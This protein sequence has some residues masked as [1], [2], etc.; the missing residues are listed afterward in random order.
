M[1]NIGIAKFE[2]DEPVSAAWRLVVTSADMSTEMTTVE[3]T[4]YTLENIH[5]FLNSCVFNHLAPVAAC[6]RPYVFGFEDLY[7]RDE[8]LVFVYRHI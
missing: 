5:F 6:A 3:I 4:P 7:Y 2:V 8:G 1:V